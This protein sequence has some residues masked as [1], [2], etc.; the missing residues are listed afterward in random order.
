M[1]PEVFVHPFQG[2]FEFKLTAYSRSST[3]S[4]HQQS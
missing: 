1:V 4:F 3:I 2:P